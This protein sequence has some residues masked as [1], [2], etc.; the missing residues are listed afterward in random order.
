MGQVPKNLSMGS[1]LSLDT[2]EK[3]DVATR[4]GACVTS[5]NSASTDLSLVEDVDSC[6]TQT[7]RQICLDTFLS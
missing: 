4:E 2:L 7:C 1:H 3:T 6:Q 5:S